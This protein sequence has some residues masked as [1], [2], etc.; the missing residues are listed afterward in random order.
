MD[1]PELT[2]VG[3]RH[4]IFDWDSRFLGVAYVCTRWCLSLSRSKLLSSTLQAV[5]DFGSPLYPVVFAARGEPSHG[6]FVLPSGGRAS[7]RVLP[8]ES[9]E[10]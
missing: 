4:L 7:K 5:V 3:L 10:L 9:T 8:P 6:N 2:C 1:L